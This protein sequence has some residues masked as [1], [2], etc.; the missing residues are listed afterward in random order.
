MRARDAG[1]FL[2]VATFLSAAAAAADSTTV[3]PPPGDTMLVLPE[4][5]VDERRVSD[6]ERRAPTG[7]I[8]EIRPGARGAALDLLPELMSQV[9]GVHVQ[10]YGGLGAFSVMSMRGASPGQLAV[11]LDGMPLTSAGRGVVS[12]A[13]LPITAVERIEVYRGASPLGFG[14]AGPG[15]AVNLVT[16]GGARPPELRVTR[17][18]FDTWDGRGTVSVATGSLSA[19]AHLGYQ[20]SQGDFSYLD[21]NATPFNA[22]DDSLK[23]RGNNRFDAWTGLASLTWRAHPLWSVVARGHLLSK[24]QGTPGLGAIGTRHSALDGTHGMGQIELAL[25][26]RGPARPRAKLRGGLDHSR[27]RFHDPYAELGLGAHD[28]DD[29]LRSEHL[30]LEAEWARLPWGLGFEAGGTLRGER[31]VLRD[32]ADPFEDPAPSRRDRRGA[33]LA[34]ALR[35]LGGRLLVRAGQRWDRLEDEL[36]ASGAG[37]ATST[38]VTRLL[39]SPQLGTSARVGLGFEL[40][41]NWS[42][43]DRPPDFME[44]FGNQGVVLG[45][46]ALAP[47]RLENWDAGGSWTAPPTAPV[48]GSLT[49]A[50]FESRARDLILYVRNS[51]STVRAQNVSASR[52]RGEELEVSIRFAGLRGSGSL[53]WMTARDAGDIP[54]W[55]GKRLPQRPARE[56]YAR[57]GWERGG[58]GLGADVYALGDNYLDRYNR[59]RVASRTLA[60]AWISIAPRGWPFRLSLEGKNLGDRRAA[61]VAGY[62]LPGRTVLLACESRFDPASR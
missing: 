12:L 22:G 35:P 30:E 8:A 46:P 53:T 32:S 1:I 27:V 44:L 51:A 55:T 21:D 2:I 42:K 31:A 26:E 57:L 25:A 38:R 7:S 6:A 45:N 41:A 24:R 36:H 18:S 9:P 5:R 16:L 52:V 3:L 13:D 48:R 15:G 37:G 23:A 10:Q 4:V 28:T 14:A 60:G 58:L 49:L 62:P 39:R 17:G 19:V 40:R 20:G 47:E 34:L 29:R 54:Y 11:F 61:D 33:M 50:H 43:A 56:G 59:Y